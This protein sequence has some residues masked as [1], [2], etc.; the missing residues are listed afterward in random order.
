MTL[1]SGTSAMPRAEFYDSSF[2]F[3]PS[4]STIIYS[5]ININIYMYISCEKCKKI[6]YSDKT[7]IIKNTN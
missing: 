5:T 7:K 2:Q 4:F 1:I 6:V 3:I